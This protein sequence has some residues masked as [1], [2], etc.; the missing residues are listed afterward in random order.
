MIPHYDI[1]GLLARFDIKDDSLA[2][3][4]RKLMLSMTKEMTSEE[5]ELIQSHIEDMFKRFK[6]VVMEG[7]PQFKANPEA[8][9]KLATGEIFT[10]TKALQNTLVDREGF[11]DLLRLGVDE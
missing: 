6:D 5:R 1:S 7:R 10:T 2:T 9:D 11:L 4:P 8:L 3:H